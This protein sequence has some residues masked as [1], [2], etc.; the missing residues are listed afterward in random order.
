[1]QISSLRS[2]VS[3]WPLLV[4]GHHDDGGAVAADEPRLPPE[5]LFAFLE[6]DRVDDALALQ[7]LQAG[8]DHAPL[9]AVDHDRDPGD[10]GLGRDAG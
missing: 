1:M 8:L 9:G 10:V 5:L 7:A 3:A 2:T 6:A 4:E